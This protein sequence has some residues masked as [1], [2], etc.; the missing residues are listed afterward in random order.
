M[1][2]GIGV[3]MDVGMGVGIGVD[4]EVG[5]GPSA[6]RLGTGIR[7]QRRIA[8]RVRFRGPVHSSASKSRAALFTIFIY[9]SLQPW[10]LLQPT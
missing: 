7:R 1:G 4:M 2:V 9:F 8:K 5:M 10:K 6:S 3:D